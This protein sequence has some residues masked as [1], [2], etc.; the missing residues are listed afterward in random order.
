MRKPIEE[1]KRINKDKEELL[2]AETSLDR[3][4]ILKLTS[5]KGSILFLKLN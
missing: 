1:M 2:L 5:Q 4:Y 3:W